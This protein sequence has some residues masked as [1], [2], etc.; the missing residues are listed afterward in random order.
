[1]RKSQAITITIFLL[2][3]FLVRK[4]IWKNLVYFVT[5]ILQVFHV[6]GYWKNPVIKHQRPYR[7][8]LVF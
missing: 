5:F 8:A 2:L 7:Y 3:P 4:H 1:M 6:A